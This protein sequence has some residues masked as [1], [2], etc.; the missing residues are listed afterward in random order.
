MSYAIVRNEKLTRDEAKGRYVHNERKTRGH[1]NKD[2]DQERTYLNYYYKKNELSYIKEF[3]KLRKEKDLK[4]HI[5]SNS[6]IMCEMLFTSDKEFFDRIGEKETKRYFEESYKFVCNY[7]NL[8]EEN[9]LSAVVHLDEGT[10]HMHLVFVPVVHT[11]DK[12]GNE[13]DKICSKDFWKGRDSYR[14]LQNNF[15]DYIT[16][17]GFEVERGIEVEETGAK[18]IRIEE[19]KKI[20]NYEKTKQ[21][22][23]EINYE[24]PEVPKISDIKKVMLNRDE[25]IYEKIIKPKDELINELFSDNTKLRVE[26]S[27]QIRLINK[28]EKYENEKEEILEDNR[29]LHKE[30]DEFEHEYVIK[31][32]NL[33]KEY[34]ELKEELKQ[35]YEIKTRK[36]EDKYEDK[37]YELEKENSYLHKIINTF[38]KTIHKFIT[39]I[40]QKFD[41]GAENNLI[42]DFEKETGTYLD[43]EKQLQKE[44]RQKEKDMGME[45]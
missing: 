36:I 24:L 2:I 27:K 35:D 19:L 16:S 11:K 37:I 44:E 31:T 40:C 7:K 6:I 21:V 34:K 25:K 38:E 39:W 4:G 5:K 30:V 45:L 43:A 42:K 10:P 17:K 12:A 26:L 32:R 20:T 18:N 14:S 1:T 28:A 41:M 23:K 15:Y 22:L 8:G 9:I 29:A 13:I 3:D 33:E